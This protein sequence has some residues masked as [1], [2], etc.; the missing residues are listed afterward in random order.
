M[1]LPC[2]GNLFEASEGPSGLECN[3]LPT[4][5]TRMSLFPLTSG[6]TSH[7]KPAV[8]YATASSFFGEDH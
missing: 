7:A 5:L 3:V 4:E 8:A 2:S 6:A 1:S